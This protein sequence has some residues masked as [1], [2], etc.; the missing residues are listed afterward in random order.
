[1]NKAYLSH[2]AWLSAKEA[3]HRKYIAQLLSM[4]VA[5]ATRG[6]SKTVTT[7]HYSDGFMDGMNSALE[8]LQ[9]LE[10]IEVVTDSDIEHETRSE[11]GGE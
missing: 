9:H 3:L 5:P 8:M 10:L 6:Q 4:G 11:G 2:S 7:E 1:M